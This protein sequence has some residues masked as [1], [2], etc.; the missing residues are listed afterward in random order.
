M[1]AILGIAENKQGRLYALGLY[2][3][4]AAFTF[5][6]IS[7]PPPGPTEQFNLIL[8]AFDDQGTL[9]SAKIVGG[10]ERPA[11]LESLRAMLTIDDSGNLYAALSYRA[12]TALQE[13][14]LF[15]KLDPQA[16][17]L[18]SAQITGSVPGSRYAN[19]SLFAAADGRLYFGGQGSGKIEQ[20]GGACPLTIGE[21]SHLVLGWL[22][23][24][25]GRC[26]SISASQS[27]AGAG[28]DAEALFFRPYPQAADGV[29][30]IGRSS[31]QVQYA[32]RSLG[33]PSSPS[34]TFLLR[35]PPTGTPSW[36][37]ELPGFSFDDRLRAST[38]DSSGTFSFAIQSF[39]EVTLP[40]GTP[41]LTQGESDTFL[42]RVDRNGTILWTAHT[43]GF[44]EESI[45]WMALEPSGDTF[46]LAGASK[47]SLFGSLIASSPYQIAGYQGRLS[48]QGQWTQ[49]SPVIGIFGEL[50]ADSFLFTQSR[51][52][53]LAGALQRPLFI[54]PFALAP[55]GMLDALLVCIRVP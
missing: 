20:T 23:Q 10:L 51:K 24:Q 4:K 33:S 9:L 28:G 53:C 54:E 40:S 21:G 1:S 52:L 13:A 22:D 26:G 5:G 48:S 47:G 30:L 25:T 19:R 37:L 55:Q 49:L 38:L 14:T 15:L 2:S 18:W 50:S 39:G 44:G 29:L 12:P 7:L 35:L 8:A 45:V 34:Q 46:F 36:V 3:A 16:S 32:G 6:S 31:G 11:D 41:H 17:I 43:Q 42:F 27:I